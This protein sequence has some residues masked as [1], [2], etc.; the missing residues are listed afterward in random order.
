[1]LRLQAVL[2]LI[3]LCSTAT[4][5][6]ADY[7]DRPIRRIVPQAAGSATDDIAR[8]LAAALAPQIGQPV[9]V[10]NR[11]GGAPEDFAELIRKESAKWAEVVGRSG[12]KID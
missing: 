7:P 8:L 10:E 12:A 5:V 3:A 9:V 1:M 6:A 2:L 11:P 4:G